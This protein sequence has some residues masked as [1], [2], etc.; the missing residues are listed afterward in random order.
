M[1]IKFRYDADR[2][3]LYETGEGELSYQDFTEYRANLLA[4]PIRPASKALVLA[5]YR[6]ARIALSSDEMWQ[7]KKQSDEVAGFFGGAKVAIVAPDDLGFGMARMYSMVSEA[8]DFEG[9]V[10]KTMSEA[11]AWLGIEE[12]EGDIM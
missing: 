9:A 5:D 2:N 3:I 4:Q 10:F 1:P 6:N 12:P 11:R 7:I 8:G